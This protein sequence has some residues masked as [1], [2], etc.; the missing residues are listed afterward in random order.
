MNLDVLFLMLIGLIVICYT[1]YKIVDR[2]SKHIEIV[3]GVRT[4]D[5]IS[6]VEFSIGGS[7]DDEEE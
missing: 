6:K 5:N 2:I 1:I 4:P 7:K 3:K